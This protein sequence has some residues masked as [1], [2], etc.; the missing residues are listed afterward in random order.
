MY[1]FWFYVGQ[2][3]PGISNL[4]GIGINTCYIEHEPRIQIQNG[5]K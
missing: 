3:E 1:M 4:D 2:A 5:S